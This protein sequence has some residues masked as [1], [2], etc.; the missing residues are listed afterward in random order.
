MTPRDCIPRI[1]AGAI[2]EPS[3]GSSPAM[4]SKFRPPNGT[5]AK[6]IPGPKNTF[7]P[8]LT[9]SPPIAPPQACAKP[10]SNV[11]AT[12]N[13][14]GHCVVVPGW[15]CARNPC[16]PSFMRNSG[17][18]ALVD[19]TTNPLVLPMYASSTC[20]PKSVSCSSRDIVDAKRYARV[21]A[22]LPPTPASSDAR[23]T[24]VA[25]AT[26]AAHAAADMRSALDAM[27]DV[28]D[29]CARRA[30]R[31]TSTKSPASAVSC[32]DAVDAVD[33]SSTAMSGRRSVDGDMGGMSRAPRARVVDVRADGCGRGDV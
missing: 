8:F 31:S 9:N 30:A 21:R 23:V 20:P 17:T 13:A 22:A 33:A 16:G 6:F 25:T 5:R 28:V 7:A 10:T 1:T 2:A 18:L 27:R 15:L 32:C 29:A 3:A 24:S 26:S 14:H 11:A 19:D 12:A 4:Y